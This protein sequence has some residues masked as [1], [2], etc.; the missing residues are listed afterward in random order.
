M[1]ARCFAS[2][3]VCLVS[4]IVLVGG[5][6]ATEAKRLQGKWACV[7]AEKDGRK[8]PPEILKFVATFTDDKMTF[9]T[10]DADK[11]EGPDK[12]EFKIVLDPSKKPKWIDMVKS[13]EG[14][15][16]MGIYK[17]EGDEL[18]I[19]VGEKDVERPSE[20]AAPEGSKLNLITFKK[21]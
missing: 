8:A 7:A 13:A 6:V 15:G 16:A 20:F 14:K 5:D 1:M 12:R 17:L 18:T 11:K 4:A 9:D 10:T 3:V 2:V 21:K 19:C